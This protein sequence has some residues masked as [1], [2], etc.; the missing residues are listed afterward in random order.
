ML[1][2]YGTI[3]NIAG[4]RTKQRWYKGRLPLSGLFR[5]QVGRLLRLPQ[6]ARK[7]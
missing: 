7:L 6:P 4:R 3:G 2:E 1:A 5:H